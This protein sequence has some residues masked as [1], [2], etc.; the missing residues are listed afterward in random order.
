MNH[1][2]N[3]HQTLGAYL[4]LAL[5]TA[6]TACGGSATPGAGDTA[7][8]PGETTSDTGA[9]ASDPPATSPGI[10]TASD[11]FCRA[12][13]TGDVTATLES[14]GGISTISYG[15]WVPSSAGTVAGI[16]L[17]DTFFIMNCSGPG[18]ELLS[19][20]LNLDQH[21]PMAPASYSIRKADN[22]LG[23]YDSNPPVIHVS[24]FI[25]SGDFVWA[26][27]ADSVF[28]VTE[29][30]ATHIAGDFVLYVQEAK[31]DLVTDGLPAKSAVITG[32][33]NLKN[34]N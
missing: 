32:S 24:P 34:P 12:E 9:V 31:N 8:Q 33:F 6:I 5:L 22:T 25:G 11:D 7:S 28:N 3:R 10:T 1:G 27:S 26:I 30:D 17:D 21:L 19:I 20:G 16:T 2:T 4:G 23:G 18:G 29:F 15:P 13:I 14:G